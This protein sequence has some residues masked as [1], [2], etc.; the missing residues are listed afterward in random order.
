MADH[1]LRQAWIIVATLAMLLPVA[2]GKQA[3][4]VAP[5]AV[6][7]LAVVAR[8]AG[9]LRRAERLR[10]A[11]VA[12][13]V[14]TD[15]RSRMRRAGTLRRSGRFEEAWEAFEALRDDAAASPPRGM[16]PA[17]AA[18]VLSWVD[19]SGDN[20][21]WATR[22]YD[23][24]VESVIAQYNAKPSGDLA[25]EI[26]KTYGRFG[27]W[28]K[29]MEWIRRAE[30]EHARAADRDGAGEGVGRADD[31]GAGGERGAA[32]EGVC[33]GEGDRARGGLG[34]RA[35]AEDGR[36]RAIGHR[37]LRGRDRTAGERAIGQ[38]DGVRQRLAVEV[39]RARAA[40]RDDGRAEGGVVSR[41]ERAGRDRSRAAEASIRAGDGQGIHPHRQMFGVVFHNPQRQDHRQVARHGIPD[42]MG[43]HQLIPHQPSSAAMSLVCRYRR[44]NSG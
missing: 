9:G 3:V 36:D 16:S 43:P 28:P 25:W 35:R 23:V 5:T 14:P 30:R 2:N 34:Q 27:E 12:A 21:A 15:A 38:R 40:D 20:F 19:E 18:E 31:Q 1:R 41:L 44:W 39:E 7:E 10:A 24:F 13:T 26:F 17:E 37:E 8:E 32:R 6:P 33:A 11:G 22:K 42:L 4:L 29:A